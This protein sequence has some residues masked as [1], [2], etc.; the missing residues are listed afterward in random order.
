[1]S[2]ADRAGTFVAL[3][4]LLGA[5]SSGGQAPQASADPCDALSIA[6]C[7]QLQ[8]CAPAELQVD[9][10]DIETCESQEYFGCNNELTASDTGLTA[11]NENACA[12]ALGNQTCGDF[13]AGVT[14]A[15]CNPVAGQRALGA[16]CAFSSQCAS[17]F[18]AVVANTP[19]GTCLPPPVAGTSCAS[20]A[21]G[22][23]GGPSL[24]CDTAT[25]TCEP[26]E[27]PLAQCDA[28]HPCAGGLT[29][30]GQTP[31]A[32]SGQCIPEGTTPGAACDPLHQTAPD[33]EERIGLVCEGSPPACGQ[34]TLAGNGDACGTVGQQVVGCEDG[35]CSLGT[36]TNVCQGWAAVDLNC[37][38]QV[39]PGCQGPARCITTNGIPGPGTCLLP[40]DSLC[41]PD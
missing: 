33:C 27:P 25:E 22:P 20:T 7:V 17:T 21:C 37:D 16:T 14:P 18:C 2:S 10:G 32:L 4:L 26:P 31:A 38:T 5:C 40:A 15:S 30:L 23:S 28:N 36:Q 8:S 19:C 12:Q 1:M 35:S 34:L 24:V 41:T 29:C 39:G 9:Y 13:L 3:S 11:S 6:R